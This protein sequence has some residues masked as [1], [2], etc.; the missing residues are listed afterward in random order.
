MAHKLNKHSKCMDLKNDLIGSCF[1][2]LI[3]I[4]SVTIYV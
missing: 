4:Q 2:L 3:T 1:K